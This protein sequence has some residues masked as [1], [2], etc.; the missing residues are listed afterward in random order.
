MSDRRLTPANGRVA[1]QHLRGS[2]EAERF[3]EGRPAAIAAPVVDLMSTP[4]GRRDRQLL[5]GAAVTVYED[6]DGFAF[7][8]AA[9]DGYVGYVPTAALGP[10]I[11]PTHRVASAATHLYEGPDMKSPDLACLPRA[12]GLAVTGIQGR[13]A[14]TRD[15]FVPIQHLVEREERSDDPAAVAELYLGVPYL[16]GGNSSFGI[17]CSGLVQAACRA[18]GI[19]CP[20]DSDLQRA[21]LGKPIAAE[22]TVRRGDLFFWTGHVAMA[23]DAGTLIHANAHRMA[24]TTERLADA[25]ARIARQ[26]DGP[27]LARRRP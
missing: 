17:D 25:I 23:L 6:R 27:V 16:W 13:F 9:A 3:V 19:A 11:T 2:V 26:G 10:E 1:A 8:Q 14:E 21:G 5:M 7:V 4:D 20:G 18:C 24:V 12:A 15:G 22:A